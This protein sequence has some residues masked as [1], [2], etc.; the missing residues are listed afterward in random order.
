[1]FGNI[2]SQNSPSF[3]TKLIETHSDSTMEQNKKSNGRRLLSFMVLV[4]VLICGIVL[5]HHGLHATQE[6]TP[7]FENEVGNTVMIFFS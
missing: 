1:M 4:L 3:T 2:L 5:V 7:I 6:S